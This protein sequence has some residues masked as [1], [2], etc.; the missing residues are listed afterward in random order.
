M[1]CSRYLS[2]IKTCCGFD[3]EFF[4]LFKKKIEEIAPEE[5]HGLLLLDEMATRKNITMDPKTKTFKGTVNHGEGERQAES[6]DEV[7][8]KG[9]VFMYQPLTNAHKAQ[10]IAYFAT[11]KCDGKELTKLIIKAIV[12]LENAGVKVHGVITDAG[13][14]NRGFWKEVRVSGKL[15]ETKSYFTHPLDKER[16]VFVFSD[17]PHL[18]KTVRNRLEKK[19]VLTVNH[20]V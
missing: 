10:P 5:R 16:K 13:G 6:I 1:F 8:D 4:E 12:L 2:K 17:T 19:K 20:R 9:L 7:A 11:S 15:D 14:P 3:K 18:I